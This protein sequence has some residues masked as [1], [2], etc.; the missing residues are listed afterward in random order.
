M[1]V[2]DGFYKTWSNARATF[3]EGTPHGGESFDSSST[4]RQLQSNVEG[5]KPG[6][7]WSGSASES[8]SATNEKQARVLGEMASLDQRLRGEVDRAANVV[9]AGRRDLE[10]V[11]QWVQNAAALVPNP[12]STQ[13]Q[14]KLMPIVSKGSGEI[15]EILQRSNAE[16]NAIAGRIRGL[17]SEYRMLGGDLKLGEG[18][19]PDDGPQMVVGE[20]EEPWRYPWEPPPPS[21]SAPGGGRWDLGQGYPPGP[22]GG[23]PM[24]PIASPS[25]WRKDV[26]PPIAGG[27]SGLQDVVAP[28]PNG[29]GAKPPLV[30]KEGYKFR[31]TGETFNGAPD[32]VQ[33][34]EKGGMWYQAQWVDYNFEAEHIRQLVGNISAPP[35]GLNQW[36]PINIKDIYGIQVDNPRLPLY[37]PNPF[38]GQVFLDPKRSGVA[39]G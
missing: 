5:A 28:L 1:G 17:D 11:R 12:S 3:G 23:P 16:S 37:V 33:W 22:N 27:P 13:G 31:V 38:G 19:E 8:Y 25:P 14:I 24:G 4:L 21:D 9:S 26:I 7:Q 18:N 2:L 32:H 10:S 29:W 20:G 15:A 34:V 35:M 39:A 6:S 36:E 30:L